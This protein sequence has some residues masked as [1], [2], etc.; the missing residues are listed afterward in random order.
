[1]PILLHV[2]DPLLELSGPVA[3][4]DAVLLERGLDFRCGPRVVNRHLYLGDSLTS[5]GPSNE[6]MV[7][8]LLN[9]HLEVVAHRFSV[10]GCCCLHRLD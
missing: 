4:L 1:L 9:L 8:L 3:E 6:V 2:R 5:Q 10:L 7:G